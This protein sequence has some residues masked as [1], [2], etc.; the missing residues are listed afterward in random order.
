MSANDQ[1]PV[2]RHGKRM[3]PLGA[4]FMQR[5]VTPIE[6]LNWLQDRG[7]ISYECVTMAD[8][9]PVDAARVVAAGVARWR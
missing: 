3:S 7:L 9:A 4:L 5:C 2:V 1:P 6:G 8:V